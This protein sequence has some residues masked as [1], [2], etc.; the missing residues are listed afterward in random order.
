MAKISTVLLIVFT[1][2][3]DSFV[4]CTLLLVLKD[5][6][7]WRRI[8]LEKDYFRNTPKQSA[9]KTFI[10]LK[11]K[12]TEV[13]VTSTFILSTTKL[14]SIYDQCEYLKVTVNKRSAMGERTLVS[15]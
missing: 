8:D 7:Q 3:I 14:N 6:N 9:F 10:F 15:L 5:L 11:E 2:E 13:Q 1:S 12:S 4:Y